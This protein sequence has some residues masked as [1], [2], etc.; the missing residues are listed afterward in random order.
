MKY[1]PPTKK[2]RIEPFLDKLAE[3][4]NIMSHEISRNQKDMFSPKR[5]N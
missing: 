4:Q 3:P 1:Y 5:G 2:N